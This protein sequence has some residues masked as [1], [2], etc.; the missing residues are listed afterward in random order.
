[1]ELFL[2]KLFKSIIAN[3]NPKKIKSALYAQF[4]R[5]GSLPTEINRNKKSFLFQTF[6]SSYW[7]P[8]N[9]DFQAKSESSI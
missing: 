8:P 2:F 7:I 6:I 9:C 5:F 4:K 1:M 3:S